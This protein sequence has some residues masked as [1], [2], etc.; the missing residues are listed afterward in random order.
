MRNGCI[1]GTPSAY[2]T[3]CLEMNVDAN[4]DIVFAEYLL[5]D[6]KLDA[7]INSNVREYERLVRRVMS[8][9]GRPALV[10]MQTFS[11]GV[12]LHL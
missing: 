12:C 4:V 8:L 2:M 10:L 6:G 7:I 9:P 1:A 3:V 11:H 5:N